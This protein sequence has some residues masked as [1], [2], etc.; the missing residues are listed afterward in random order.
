MHSSKV[1][2]GEE[3]PIFTKKN[4]RFNGLSSL[5]TTTYT[6]SAIKR[7]FSRSLFL[8]SSKRV[9]FPE[10]ERKNKKVNIKRF[11]LNRTPANKNELSLITLHL[12]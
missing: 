7:R 3:K 2:M 1:Q 5:F 4:N 6:F 12:G 10:P 8:S 11:D 9:F